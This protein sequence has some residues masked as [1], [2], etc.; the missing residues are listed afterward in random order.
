MVDGVGSRGRGGGQG[1]GEGPTSKQR[2]G[3][4]SMREGE[5]REGACWRDKAVGKLSLPPVCLAKPEGGSP[6]ELGLGRG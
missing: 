2:R 1:T 4:L 3:R 5:K 6:A